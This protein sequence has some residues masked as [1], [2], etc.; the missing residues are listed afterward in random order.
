MYQKQLDLMMLFLESVTW[1]FSPPMD[2]KVPR[3]C[4]SE[5]SAAER[6]PIF[7]TPVGVHRTPETGESAFGCGLGRTVNFVPVSE[8][9][10]LR[11]SIF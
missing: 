4:H 10:R 8:D 1:A 2:M 11:L 3:A 9:D 6:G 7:R 5:C